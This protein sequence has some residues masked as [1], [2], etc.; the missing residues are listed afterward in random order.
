[1]FLKL[2]SQLLDQ[3]ILSNLV[4]LSRLQICLIL[5]IRI[6]RRTLWQELRKKILSLLKK[7]ENLCLSSKILFTWMIEE[8]KNFLKLWIIKNLL[9][10]L[11]P[12]LMKLR[13][14]SLEIC[15]IVLLHCFVK[16]LKLW[17]RLKFLM[18]KK[19][20]KILFNSLKSWKFKARRLFLAVVKAIHS[21]KGF[22]VW[23]SIK[24]QKLNLSFFQTYRVITL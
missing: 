15:L 7:L 23:I 11:K 19:L 21:Y 6:L 17:R 12:L 3:S 16:T 14:S 2:N 24:I 22:E 18:L 1:M 9:F 10:L 13:V 4:V 8:F 20:N 5:W